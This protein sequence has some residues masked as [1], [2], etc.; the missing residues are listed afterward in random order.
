MPVIRHTHVP[1][2]EREGRTVI[3]LPRVPLASPY[4]LLSP[5]FPLERRSVRAAHDV[6][7]QWLLLHSPDARQSVIPAL[8][9]G[10]YLPEE[11]AH[12]YRL[13]LLRH[14]LNR[15][16]IGL[17]LARLAE[18]AATHTVLIT[19]PDCFSQPLARA[20]SRLSENP[21]YDPHLPV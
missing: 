8:R 16:V 18:H 5:P 15:D 13:Y 3:P 10:H 9:R 17:C 12:A 4:R 20:V 2:D 6:S 19:G 21:T 14:Y 1:P 7:A 11:A